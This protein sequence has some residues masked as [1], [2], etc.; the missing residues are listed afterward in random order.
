M[1]K[2]LLLL[3]CM[4]GLTFQSYAQGK[5]EQ[6]NGPVITWEKKT[7]DFGNIV[8]GEQIQHTFYF[9]NTGNEPLI[10]TS[11]QIDC[12]CT[13]AKG[14]PRDPVPPGG[15]GEITVTFDSA[16]KMGIQKKPVTLVTNAMNPDGNTIAFTTNIVEKKPG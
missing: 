2:Y 4:F 12:A 16:A 3:L 11:V 15:S 13:K 1:K 14:W 9:T 5:A 10:I 7:H 6:K 8:Q